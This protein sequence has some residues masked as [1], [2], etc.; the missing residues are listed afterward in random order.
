MRPTRLTSIFLIA[1]L[2]VLAS[3]GSHGCGDGYYTAQVWEDL[4][5]DG[6]QSSEEKPLC[7]VV[8][9]IVNSN[10]M[11]WRRP[12]TD[13]YGIIAEYD[14]TGVCARRCSIHLSIPSDY[15]PTTPVVVDPTRPSRCEEVRFGLQPLPKV[16][17]VESDIYTAV[18]REIL[19]PSPRVSTIYIERTVVLT[20]HGN[21]ADNAGLELR[22]LS[23]ST[24]EAIAA[25]LTDLSLEVVWL[26]DHEEVLDPSNRAVPQD[27]VVIMLGDVDFRTPTSVT[28]HG[29]HYYAP[30]AAGG[31][32]YVLEQVDDIWRVTGNTGVKWVS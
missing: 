20:M 14:D 17:E 27:S 11:V 3:C 32:T 18:I 7:G 12:M 24:Q 2:C 10:G 30:T 26:D 5:G 19:G 22:E 21:P 16:F 6:E 31:Q 15:W 8:V 1:L 13:I 28:V 23:Q 4:D 25:Q 9:Q 29:L